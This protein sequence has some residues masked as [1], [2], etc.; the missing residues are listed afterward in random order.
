LNVYVWVDRYQ[1]NQVR[2]LF[3]FYFF[4]SYFKHEIQPGKSLRAERIRT[5][6]QRPFYDLVVTENRN[7][8]KTIETF[9][10]DAYGI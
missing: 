1:T 5:V 9:D 3:N 8:S 6:V 2:A 4:G 10:L 7:R